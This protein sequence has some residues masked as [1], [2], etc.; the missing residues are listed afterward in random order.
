ME[1]VVISKSEKQTQGIAS[2]LAKTFQGGEVV[3]LQGDLGA[4]KTAFTKGLALAL[5]IDDII[6]SPTFTI[7][8]EHYGKNLNLYHFDMYRL[9]DEM[10]L[11][12]L[13]FDE[14]VGNKQGVC[15][16]EWFEKTPSIL[17]DNAVLVTIEKQG[18]NKRKITITNYKR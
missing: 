11:K 3:L 1:E 5:N 7:L 10:E 15:A 17:P 8:N 4:G 16:I 13:G 6:T 18:I 14:Y 12:E 2:N 9:D